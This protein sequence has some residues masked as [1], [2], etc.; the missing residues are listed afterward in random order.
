[1]LKAFGY[2]RVSTE[3]QAKEGVSLENQRNK[4][5]LYC[6]MND[7]ELIGIESDEGISAKDLKRPGVRRILEM[8]KNRE[9]DAIVIY[10]LDRMFR[11]T[12]DALN[13]A[14]MLDKKGIALHSINE[15]LDTQSAIGK[16]FFTLTAS[17]AEME[18]N[19]ISE[20][21]S[22]AMQSMKARGIST[23]VVQYGFMLTP[24][25]KHIIPDPEEQEI[26]RQII[27]LR[28]ESLSFQKI[29]DKLNEQGY[30]N[31]AGN[32]WRPQYICGIYKANLKRK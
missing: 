20:R 11:S 32:H 13:T 21:T 31:R 30:R 3:E 5:E 17:L 26:I 29:A 8:A 16:F 14:T 15:K 19:I 28:S 25:G 6:R 1:M 4:I 22:D 24:N 18:R 10:K 23:G 2:V 12:I 27:K 7:F 9:I